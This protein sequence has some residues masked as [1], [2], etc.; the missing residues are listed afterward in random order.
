MDKLIYH[1]TGSEALRS[2]ILNQT[3]WI[4]KSDYLNDSTE[5]LVIKPILQ[6]FFKQH[7]SMSKEVQKYISEQ[8][9]Y[10][11]NEYNYYILS[12]SK[13]D[14]S[15]PLWNYYSENEGYSIGIDRAEFLYMFSE[16]FKEIDPEV[17]VIN[18]EVK[19]IDLED[20]DASKEI[21]EILLPFK[22]FSDDDLVKKRSIIDDLIKVLANQSFSIKHKA[23]SAEEEERIVVIC[24]KESP[25]TFSEEFRVLNGSFIPYIVF[26]K[27]NTRGLT[28]P[29]KKVKINPYPTMDFAQK[30]VLYLLK[31]RYKDF[32]DADIVQ[33]KI[34]ARY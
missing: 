27:G 33:S 7:I 15:L 13:V 4:T 17:S 32:K 6:K 22:F 10:Y 31:K 19:Y 24:K 21:K 11:L 18:T 3:F 2:I 34:P 23:Y 28:L 8:L 26:N 20:E 1:F 14:D 12:C 29:I 9:E 5:Q 16:Y 30:S 25:I